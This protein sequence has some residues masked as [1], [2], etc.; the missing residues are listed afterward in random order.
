MA[1]PSKPLV[2][3]V[4]GAILI[5]VVVFVQSG[6]TKGKSKNSYATKKAAVKA[7]KSDF[8]K[9]D[10]EAKFDSITTP[11]RNVFSPLIARSKGLRGFISGDIGPIGVP[12]ELTL[13]Q[14]NWVYSGMAEVNNVPTALLENNVTQEGVFVRLGEKW[15]LATI[16]RIRADEI[17]L[18]GPDGARYTVKVNDTGMPKIDKGGFQPLKVANGLQG[19]IGG[20][21]AG[22]IE[23]RPVG[24]SGNGSQRLT[25]VQDIN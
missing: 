7:D 23:V 25:N 17:V 3:I 15:K 8:T 1:K 11:V 6:D 9:E 5:A 21:M 16:Y 12:A 10:Y 20:S 22:N 18:S 2:Y 4:I 14:P 24:T 13:G 19:P